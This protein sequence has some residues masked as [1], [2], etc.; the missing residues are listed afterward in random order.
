M[1]FFLQHAAPL[2]IAALMFAAFATTMVSR[3]GSRARNVF[4]ICSLLFAGF[5]VVM[6]AANVLQGNPHVYSIGAAMPSLTTAAGLPIRIILVAD[7]ASVLASLMALTIA[8]AAAV[9]SIRSTQQQSGADKFFGLLLLLSAALLGL[10]FTGDF[11]TM[12][13]F[14]EIT[15]IASAAMIAF[16]SESKGSEAAFK[17]M[18]LSAIAGLFFLLGVSLLYGKY[19]LLNMAGI[20]A[21]AAMQF[22]FVDAAALSL[23]AG[24]LLL[25][26]GVFPVH[27]WKPDAFQEAPVQ[28]TIM[29]VASGLLCSYAF[30]RIC[31]S[32]FGQSA[33]SAALGWLVIVLAVLSIF[34]GVTMALVQNNLR[35]LVGY[36]AIAEAGYVLLPIGVGLAAMPNVSGFAFTALSGGLFHLLNDAIDLAL[37]L[38]VIG[39]VLYVTKKDERQ[40]GGLAHSYPVLAALFLIASMAVSGMPPFNGFASKLLIFES[41]YY[42][43]PLLSIVAIVGS[44]AMLAVFIKAFVALFLGIPVKGSGEKIPK[45]MLAVM[46]A[47]AVLIILFGIFPQTVLAVLIKPAAN[48]LINPNAY[49]GGI[50]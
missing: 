17:Y 21:A 2:S 44:I 40:L 32:V 35:R 11:F 28:V 48:A 39:A 5:L 19:G 1:N 4:T 47:L 24:A 46:L 23:I 29:L 45:S 10:S 36:A 14:L 26:A 42:F 41:V 33:L 37:L 43:N 25:K 27:M 9:S 13:V 18:I 22:S 3:A 34:V 16:N 38:L 50:L 15:S 30:A 20:A 12:F 7:A 31:F 8:L 6:L 49:I